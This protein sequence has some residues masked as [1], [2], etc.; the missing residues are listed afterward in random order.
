MGRPIHVGCSGWNYGGWRNGAFYPPRLPA[1]EWLGF[2]AQRFDVVEVNATFY[3]LQK[4]EAVARW[5]DQTPP[6]FSFAVKASRY[7]THVRRLRDLDRGIERFYDSIAPLVEHRRLAAVLWQLPATFKRD[8]AR[9]RGALEAVEHLPPGRHAFEFRD[10]SWFVPEVEELLA[11]HGA[12]LVIA[13]RKGLDF[14]TRAMTAPF[15]FVRF[16]YGDRGRDGNYSRSELQEWAKTL[17]GWS[18]EREVYAFFNNDWKA[19]AP[20]N[21]LELRRLLGDRVPAVAV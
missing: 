14:Q 8:D 20:A 1:R 7:L 6:G 15:A 21:A 9:L 18:T 2:Y 19:F 12:A 13:H 3:R 16:H 10:P 5:V 17:A 4:P 11:V